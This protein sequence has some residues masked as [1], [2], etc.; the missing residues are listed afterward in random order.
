MKKIKCIWTWNGIAKLH[1]HRVYS[2]VFV[3]KNWKNIFIN[4]INIIF[5]LLQKIWVKSLIST[6]G[7]KSW[8]AI[9]SQIVQRF[10]FIFCSDSYTVYFHNMNIFI[11]VCMYVV[12]LW[13]IL[14]YIFLLGWHVQ[15]VGIFFHSKT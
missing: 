6:H 12:L 1:L 3:K 7:K 15:E 13:P 4:E 2:W 5:Y 9:D 10:I 14:Y 11:Y 8:I